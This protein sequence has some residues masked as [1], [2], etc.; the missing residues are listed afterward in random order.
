MIA[1]NAALANSYDYI[2]GALSVFLAVSVS[3]AALDLVPG[4]HRQQRIALASSF[5]KKRMAARQIEPPV[6]R[7]AP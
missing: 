7:E 3:Y 4:A 2:R 6:A 1:A 5:L